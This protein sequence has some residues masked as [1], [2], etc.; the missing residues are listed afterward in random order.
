MM[1]E[2]KTTEYL[3]TFFDVNQTIFS[4]LSLKEILKVLV[5]KTVSALGAKAGSLR[6]L[7]EQTKRL[8]LAASQN[9][10]KKYLNKGPLS[11]DQSIPEVMEG[12]VVLV[13]NAHNDS[14][15]QYRTEKIKEGINTIL[16]VPV[17]A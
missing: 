12:K 9:L 6:L 5:K 17:V 14:R 4:S 7:D 3:R 13:K 2:H 10:S 11:S 8:E 16:S 1:V 15:I